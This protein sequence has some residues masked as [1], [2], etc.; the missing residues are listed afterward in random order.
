MTSKALLCA[1]AVLVVSLAHGQFSK[2]SPQQ[3]V[4]LG[5][6]AA[7]SLRK[8][9][10]VLPASDPRVKL[11]RKIGEKL[12]ATFHDNK[13]WTFSFDVIQSKEVNAFALPGGPTFIYTGL[14]DKLKTEDELAGVMGHELTHVRK[15]HWAYAYRDS[16]QH[17]LGL[18]A[19]LMILH[20]NNSI[21]NIASISDDLV[22]NLPFSRKHESEADAGGLDMMVSAGYNPEG[23]VDA[24][25]LLASLAGKG[26]PPEFLSD[27]PADDRRIKAMQAKIDAMHR[28]F[29]P[30]RS[31]RLND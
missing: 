27:H 14:L 21:A 25:K 16:Q 4:D 6:R 18:T 31:I 26:A 2:P 22:F 29:P 15:E 10:K 30:Q 9:E 3:Q 12:T 13:P 19:L 11:V 5:K 1:A 8:Q 23:I 7:E 17:Q 28:T 24:F 20:A